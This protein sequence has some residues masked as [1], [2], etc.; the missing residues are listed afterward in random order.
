MTDSKEDV[1]EGPGL[2]GR[3][4]WP[5]KGICP[6]RMTLLP[7][8]PPICNKPCTYGSQTLLVAKVMG[9]HSIFFYSNGSIKCLEPQRPLNGISH[10][11]QGHIQGIAFWSRGRCPPLPQRAVAAR[12]EANGWILVLYMT[13]KFKF[14]SNPSEAAV[15][16]VY[17]ERP[18]GRPLTWKH[19]LW[20]TFVFLYPVTMKIF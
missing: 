5:E 2:F 18:V 12:D 8:S 9:I 7:H 13:Q 1:C 15:I 16:M 14:R 4:D 17:R 6:R 3:W 11:A 10:P 20:P 19:E